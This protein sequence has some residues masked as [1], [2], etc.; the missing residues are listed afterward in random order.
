MTVSGWTNRAE[1]PS[2]ARDRG[3]E[4]THHLM[5]L[6]DVPQC[7]QVRL[8]SDVIGSSNDRPLFVGNTMIEAHDVSYDTTMS[9]TF[10]KDGEDYVTTVKPVLQEPFVA[11]L[12]TYK[13]DNTTTH[14][15]Y[16]PKCGNLALLAP[17]PE[18]REA[19]YDRPWSDG[20]TGWGGG[21]TGSASGQRSDVVEPGTVFLIIV[22]VLVA[23]LSRFW[24][25]RRKVS[26][27]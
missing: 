3:F 12:Y 23:G 7:A 2:D 17:R 9:M 22:G 10:R 18:L 6:L 25:D 5:Q 16:M 21:F 14:V 24:K 27:N 19:V 26:G 13:C 1:H 4:V 11:E 15:A 8:A 20:F